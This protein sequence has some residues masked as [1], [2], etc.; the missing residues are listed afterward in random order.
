MDD[1]S[2][3]FEK[4]DAAVLAESRKSPLEDC[5]HLPAMRLEEC[6]VLAGLEGG[7]PVSVQGLRLRWRI[8][9]RGIGFIVYSV[10]SRLC[11]I[12]HLSDT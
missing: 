8:R 6:D 1:I 10:L 9:H 11:Q 3:D 2:E 7:M 12:D 5:S 4:L